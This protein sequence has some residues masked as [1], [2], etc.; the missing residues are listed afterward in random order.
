MI[1]YTYDN[2]EV[3]SKIENCEMDAVF[4]IVKRHP[5]LSLTL[6]MRVGEEVDSDWRTAIYNQ[7]KKAGF[8]TLPYGLDRAIIP[9]SFTGVGR[10]LEGDVYD[11]HTGVETANHKMLKKYNTSK[12]KAMKRWVNHQKRILDGC[13][14]NESS[15]N[16]I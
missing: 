7:Y 16:N 11:E 5:Y 8:D 15:E 2:N 12:D 4:D 14:L 10:P 1:N 6:N 13:V 3:V 9:N